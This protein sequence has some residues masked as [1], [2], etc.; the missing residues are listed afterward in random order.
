MIFGSWI[1]WPGS[2][3]DCRIFESSDLNGKYEEELARLGTMALT[4]GEGIDEEIPV[5]I[6][7]DSAYR[8]SCYMVTTYKVTECKADA[9]VRHLNFQLSKAY[10]KVEHAFG[11]LKGWFYVFEKPLRSTGKD[12]PFSVYLISSICIIH[13]FLIDEWDPVPEVDILRAMA[14]RDSEVSKDDVDEE[15]GGHGE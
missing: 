13:N 6:L 12:L 15:T 8:N 2:V 9:S 7:R 5:F 14:E 11:L 1:S 3:G 4:I 10:Y